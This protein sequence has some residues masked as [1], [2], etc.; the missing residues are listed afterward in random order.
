MRR[1]LTRLLVL[2]TILICV[3][4]ASAQSDHFY[5]FN[6]KQDSVWPKNF[7]DSLGKNFDLKGFIAPRSPSQKR[8]LLP[9]YPFPEYFS[10]PRLPGIPLPDARSIPDSRNNELLPRVIP[11]RRDSK[12]LPNFPGWRIEKLKNLAKI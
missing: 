7:V 10:D 5:F 8:D 9:Q 1:H 12:E 6:D 4:S 3:C 11:K 2:P